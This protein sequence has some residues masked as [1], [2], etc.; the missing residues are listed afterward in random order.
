MAFGIKKCEKSQKEF[1]LH[2]QFLH[3]NEMKVLVIGSLHRNTH[4]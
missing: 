1:F 2:A 4:C 3:Q